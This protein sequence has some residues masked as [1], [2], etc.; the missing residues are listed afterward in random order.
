MMFRTI[1]PAVLRWT[2]L[3]V[4]TLSTLRA[5][6][7]D[8]GPALA[9]YGRHD[10]AECRQLLTT[11]AETHPK[12]AKVR[13]WLGRL[14]LETGRTEDG[15]THLEAANALVATNSVYAE[16]LG[17]AYGTMAV[18]ASFF[19]R[20]GFA[21]KTLAQFQKAAELDP[22]NI[23]ARMMLIAYYLGAPGFMGG[24]DAKAAMEAEA[25]RKIDAVKGAN[26]AAQIA[27][28]ARDV[29]AG[30]TELKLAVTNHPANAEAHLNLAL[31][32]LMQQR[33]Q[34]AWKSLQKSREIAPTNALTLH[35]TGRAGMLSGTHLD[36]AESAVKQ[37]LA[38][39]PGYGF[40]SPGQAHFVLGQ[41][42]E[43]AKRMDEARQ[44]FEEALRLEPKSA[45]FAAKIRSL[46]R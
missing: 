43:R 36:E 4:L 2:T 11:L 39:R 27:F 46:R 37:Y 38:L 34:E 41:I 22:T 15:V 20:P 9:A 14:A 26:A 44:Q 8:L 24:S 18:E 21:K 10:D 16:W 33:F 23:D 6:E 35:H 29:P 19:K 5:A 31:L 30:E 3:A 40:P 13:F 42:Y 17:R 25:I 1:L 7:A 28:S 12:D 45:E 32:Q